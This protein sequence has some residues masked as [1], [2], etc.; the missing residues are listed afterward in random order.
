MFRSALAAALRHLY[1][2]KLYAA[3][4]VSGLAVGLCAAMLAG[5]YIRSQYSYDHFIPGYQDV[6]QFKMTQMDAGRPP[7]HT[8]NVPAWLAAEL[9]LRFPQVASAS[10][11]YTGSVLLRMGDVEYMAQLSSVDPD[12]FDVLPFKVLAGNAAEAMSRP[13]QLVVTR[14]LARKF[15]GDESPVGRTMEIVRGLSRAGGEPHPVTIGA[16]I[17]DIPDNSSSIAARMFVSSRTSWTTLAGY[18]VP[19]DL[20]FMRGMVSQ[21]HT[22]VR[23]RPGASPDSMQNGLKEIVSRAAAAPPLPGGGPDHSDMSMLPLDRV[24]LDPGLNPGVTGRLV[25]AAIL[26]MVILAIAAVNFVNL[27]TARSGARVL[28]VGVRKLAG[29]PRSTLALQFFGEAFIHVAIAVV[30]AVAMTEL[31]LPHIN[32]FLAADARFE[33]WK[34]PLLLGGL[35]LGTLLFG[36]LAG[37]WPALVLSALRPLRAM[38]GRRMAQGGKSMVRQ[39]LVSVQFA[40]LAGLILAAGVTYLQTDYA[41]RQAMRFDTDQVVI[42]SMSCTSARMSELRRI[43]GVRDAACSGS[44]LLGG[45]GDGVMDVTAGNGQSIHVDL[46]P[47]DDRMLG[48]YG[49]KPLAGRVPT[50][51]EVTLTGRDVDYSRR[52]LINEAAMRA[53]GF[54][55]AS[56]ALGPHRLE[57]SDY[58][59][60]GLDEIIGVV[61][62]FSM[63]SVRKR[64]GPTLFHVRPSWF[65]TISVKMRGDDVPATLAAVD[66]VW[67]DTGGRGPL[68]RVFYEERVQRMYMAMTRETYAYGY[69]AAISISLAL[70]GLLGLAASAAEQRTK[71]IGI[72]K[73]LGATTGDVLKLL[74]WQFSRPVVWANL[75]MWPLAGWAMNRWLNGFAYHIDLPFWLFPATTL[76][77][78]LIAL[79]VVSTHALRVARARPVA[80]LR[81]E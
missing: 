53:F 20:P 16:V 67:K 17:E 26:A 2:G 30:A 42:L 13:D 78:V 59:P 18:D 32:A 69:M 15:F 47:I 50:P 80:A 5:L 24:Q 79:V 57:S 8:R 66:R 39:W 21:A 76:A 11:V 58:I 43:V 48:L 68:N 56:A 1:R 74:L 28:E 14:D 75:L 6:Y 65:N 22:V 77:T 60:F 71:E 4:A 38:H 10:R 54:N 36:L 35:V 44:D 19:S 3:I 40:L 25:K 63:A 45:G 23:L 41:T 52:Y 64:V 9:K 29:A 27:L 46:L 70:L 81:Y 37:F 49:V 72:R 73:A 31:L 55:T 7:F 34:E 33:Y 12:F 51:Q 61:P 62:D